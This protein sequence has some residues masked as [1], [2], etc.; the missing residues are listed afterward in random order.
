MGVPHSLQYTTLTCAGAA[1]GASAI[2]IAHF[3][4]IASPRNFS[5]TPSSCPQTSQCP[6]LLAACGIEADTVA[7]AALYP[8]EVTDAPQPW[9]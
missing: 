5:L 6:G 7:S 3:S 8:V 9:Q 4:W 2:G 1:A